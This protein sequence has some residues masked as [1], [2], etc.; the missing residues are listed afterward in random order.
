VPGDVPGSVLL[1]P[2]LTTSAF[3]AHLGSHLSQ[4][5]ASFRWLC[6]RVHLPPTHK[7]RKTHMGP[8]AQ[9][10]NSNSLYVFPE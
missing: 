1:T 10:Y 7:M 9:I 3:S 6:S 4:E 5:E 8:N 2:E